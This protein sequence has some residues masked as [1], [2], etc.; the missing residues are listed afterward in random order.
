MRLF[1]ALNTDLNKEKVFSMEK[2]LMQRFTNVKWVEKQ[3]L[4][5]T[6]KF[7][8]EIAED[9]IDTISKALDKISALVN[10]FEFFYNGIGGFPN[11]NRAKVVFV[12]TENDEKLVELMKTVD[13]EF[14][15]LGFKKE[16]S[17]VP[18][19]TLGRVRNGSVNLNHL[20]NL[21]F[22]KLSVEAR[23]IILFKSTLTK[24]GPIYEKILSFDLHGNKL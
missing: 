5:L 21:H 14:S 23:G 3:N 2:F 12:S 8:G 7:L 4:H 15:T 1:V 9:R 22:S 18:H 11:S 16:R 20:D 19:L 24:R 6:L 10:P 17:Y 13:R